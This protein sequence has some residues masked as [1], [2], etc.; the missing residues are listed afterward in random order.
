ALL[1]GR[2]VPAFPVTDNPLALAGA[3]IYLPTRRACRLLRDSFLDIV[4][5]E[6]AVLPR[7]VAIGDV[8]EDEIAFASAAAGDIAAEALAMPD[9]LGGFERRM[10]LARLVLQWAS[11]PQVRT[12]EGAPLV[13][14]TPAAALALADDLA[15]L[16][17]DMTTRQ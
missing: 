15:R 14:N 6:A 11:S 12:A 4:K 8:D 1:G 3:T 7:I 17:D 13:A 9:G 10:L 16:M 5:R 2:L